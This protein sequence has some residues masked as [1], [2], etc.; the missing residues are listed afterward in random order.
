MLPSFLRRLKRVFVA[1]LLASL[2][3]AIGVYLLG[4]AKIL[5]SF[6]SQPKTVASI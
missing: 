2:T 6:R 4:I 1:V 3:I 5:W